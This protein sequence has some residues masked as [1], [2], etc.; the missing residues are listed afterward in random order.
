MKN[1]LSKINFVKCPDSTIFQKA[2]WWW[3]GGVFSLP[4]VSSN[5][6]PFRWQ[7][8]YTVEGEFTSVPSCTAMY[9]TVCFRN[10]RVNNT[11]VSDK[12]TC[13]AGAKK[14]TCKESLGYQAMDNDFESYVIVVQRRKN[15]KVDILRSWRQWTRL[16]N[17]WH[18]IGG[19]M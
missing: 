17:F 8:F 19:Q 2:K 7:G 10:V 13:T 14:F 1:W 12:C 18:T 5:R 16:H 3:G 9:Y 11:S 6:I 4:A 15:G